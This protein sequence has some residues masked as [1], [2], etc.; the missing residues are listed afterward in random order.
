MTPQRISSRHDCGEKHGF[1]NTANI[2]KNT[3][4]TKVKRQKLNPPHRGVMS[5]L[6]GTK[7]A[8]VEL[9]IQ[10]GNICQPL[11]VTEGL[12]LMNDLIAGTDLQRNM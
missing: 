10:M 4:R 2:S 7:E 8:L 5:P 6:A 3:I 11:T 9:C 12:K 1:A